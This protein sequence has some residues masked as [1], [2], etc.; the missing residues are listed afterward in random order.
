MPHISNGNNN[1]KDNGNNFFESVL[2]QNYSNYRLIVVDNTGTPEEHYELPKLMTILYRNYHAHISR[3]GDS[4]FY[5]VKLDQKIQARDAKMAAVRELCG[6]GD[7]VLQVDI[8][9]HYDSSKQKYME[10]GF[11]GRQAFA[12]LSIHYDGGY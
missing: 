12:V 2:Q 1:N 4:S 10:S 6:D 3:V 5:F 7:I 11:I 9:E 8:G